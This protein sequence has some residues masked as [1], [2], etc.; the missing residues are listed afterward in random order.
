MNVF[1]L[2]DA[3]T[4]RKE[5]ALYRAP[6]VGALMNTIPHMKEGT[7]INLGGS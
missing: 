5:H 2:M 4:V 3:G 1:T 7:G 6:M